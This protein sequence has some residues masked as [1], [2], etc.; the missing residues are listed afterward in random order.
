LISIIVP[1]N[2]LGGID[3]LFDSLARQTERDFELILV[4]NIK[5]WRTVLAPGGH[6]LTF[7]ASHIEPRENSF[8]LVQYCRTVNTGIAHA[9][10]ETILLLCDYSWCHP[11]MVETHLDEQSKHPGPLHLDYNYSALPELKPDF[12]LIYNQSGYD[13]TVDPIEYSRVLNESTDRYVE[14]LKAGKLDP[15][16]W[17]I[18]AE[19]L[20]EESVSE[21][22]V[23]H[24]HRPCST[25]K[26]DDWN[27]CSF[28]NESFPTEL[29]LELNG[30]DEEYDASHCYQDQEFSYRLRERG[31]PWRN[32]PAETGMVTVVNPR[33]VLN[34][35][36]LGK[37]MGY[38]RHLCD[39]ERVASKRLPV[40][41]GFS[42]REWRR[43]ELGA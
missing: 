29:F 34:V 30:L 4:D 7:Q 5:P 12:P 24:Q 2:R 28:K 27:W 22:E 21:L 31:I 42:L 37:P 10:G 18:F 11:R 20:S 35:K 23:T 14:D 41:P 9:R 38:N 17:S 39:S 15:F 6:L 13:P 40:N 32:G 25:R 36:K 8:P 43:K 33:P 3:L 19:P 16:M 1:T 26:P